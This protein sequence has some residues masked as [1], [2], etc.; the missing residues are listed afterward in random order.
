MICPEQN[1][2]VTYQRYH[3]QNYDTPSIKLQCHTPT[4]PCKQ[5]H[6]FR[7]HFVTVTN[8]V[9]SIHSVRLLG[10]ET[11]I[12]FILT[13]FNHTIISFSVFWYTYT[14]TN[15][16]KLLPQFSLFIHVVHPIGVK[17]CVLLWGC[18]VYAISEWLVMLF[19][20]YK[21]STTPVH[22]AMMLPE[23]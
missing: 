5:T 13:S 22:V 16:T 2:S 7:Y 3:A 21:F 18:K 8:Y 23:Q 20:S 14:L 9:S 10:K 4:V 6:I 15:G 12:P 19:I 17:L 11:N 1:C